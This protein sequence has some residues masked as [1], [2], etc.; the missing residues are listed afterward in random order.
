M[1]HISLKSIDFNP[2]RY[3]IYIYFKIKATLNFIHT[4]VSV[5]VAILCAKAH[6]T[7]GF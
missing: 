5:K 3:Y 1:P 2:S 6:S 4:I 7:A